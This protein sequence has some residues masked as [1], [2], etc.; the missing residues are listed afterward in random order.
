MLRYAVLLV[1]VFLQ[2]SMA[3][4]DLRSDSLLRTGAR[5]KNIQIIE[6]ALTQGA[7]VNTTDEIG[8]PPLIWAS[9]HAHCSL[10]GLL[11]ERGAAVDEGANAQALDDKGVS[12]A[13]WASQE[14]QLA[15]SDVLRASG[16]K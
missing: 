5:A 2:I 8:R 10:I 7:D 3:W 9:F 1:L 16:A 12:A 6:L 14:G 15:L 11:L 13:G 4:A